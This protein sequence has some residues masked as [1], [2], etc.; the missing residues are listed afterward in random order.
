MLAVRCAKCCRWLTPDE[1]GQPCPRCGSR[2]VVVLGREQDVAEEKAAVAR[3]L[4]ETHYQA[5]TGLQRVVRLTGD[6]DVEV[7]PT[8]PIKLLE[9]NADSVPTGVMPLWFGPAPASNIP[10]SYVIMEVTPDEFLQIR[11]HELKLPKGW[12]LG[13][14]FPKPADVRDAG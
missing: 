3:R 2:D 5:D 7:R 11:S 6:A 8:E 12:R 13:D 14:E 9:V 10:Y 4:A 1:E